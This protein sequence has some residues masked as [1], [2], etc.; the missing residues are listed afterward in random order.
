MVG[1]LHQLTKDA[2]ELATSALEL[3]KDASKLVAGWQRVDKILMKNI[4]QSLY[5]MNWSLKD[6]AVNMKEITD[7]SIPVYMSSIEDIRYADH[8]ELNRAILIP[9]T[10][11]WYRAAHITHKHVA[12]ILGVLKT[13][14]VKPYRVG[15]LTARLGLDLGF[16]KEQFETA[17]GEKLED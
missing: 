10:M 15:F 6:L 9:R 5:H 2:D 13:I 4:V 1:N 7:L 11:S 8:D 16:F 17:T 3:S 14:G 12:Q